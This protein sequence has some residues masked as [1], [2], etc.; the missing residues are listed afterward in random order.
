M[1]IAEFF[2]GVASIEAEH[3]RRYRALL[4][5][6]ET[7]TVFRRQET[8]EWR[9]RNCGYV[10]GGTEAPEKCPVCGHPRAFF[11]QKDDNY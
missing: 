10:H 6:L 1:E 9:C 4:D 7:G 11:E 5:R 2:H 8:R 3:E